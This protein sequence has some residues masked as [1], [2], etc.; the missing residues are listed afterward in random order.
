MDMHM[1]D[2]RIQATLLYPHRRDVD[3]ENGKRL[4]ELPGATVRRMVK[5]LHEDDI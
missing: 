4:E 3:D 5:S 1:Q 2:D